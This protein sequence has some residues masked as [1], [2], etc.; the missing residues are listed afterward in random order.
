MLSYYVLQYGKP[1]YIGALRHIDVELC[2]VGALAM[3]FY[4]RLEVLK[5]R[6][7]N[8]RDRSSWYDI[9]VS[10][11]QR[12]KDQKMMPVCYETERHVFKTMLQACGCPTKKVTHAGRAN[13]AK[14][15]AEA[16]VRR[17]DILAHGRWHYTPADKCYMTEIPT[18]SLLSMAGVRHDALRTAHYL[19]PR[20]MEPVPQ[21]LLDQVY[22]WLDSEL[23]HWKGVNARGDSASMDK[24]AEGFLTF[25]AHLRVVLFQDL[26][27]LQEKH[28]DLL[29]FREALWDSDDWKSYQLRVKKRAEDNIAVEVARSIPGEVA[30][31]LESQTLQMRSDIVR[32]ELALQDLRTTLQ[33]NM[34]GAS[35]SRCHHT[36]CAMHSVATPVPQATPSSARS[37]PP[38]P[39][40]LAPPMSAPSTPPPNPRVPVKLAPNLKTVLQHWDEFTRGMDGMPPLARIIRME[41]RTWRK[42]NGIPR[43][44]YH[45]RK[46]VWEAVVELGKKLHVTNN[47]AANLLQELQSAKTWS[48]NDFREWLTSCKAKVTSLVGVGQVY[49]SDLHDAGVS[50]AHASSD[51]R[52]DMRD[53]SDVERCLEFLV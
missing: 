52:D 34:Q 7:P 40:P 49:L 29:I 14:L 32:L 33:A 35:N 27:L 26:A 41:S 25:L 2:P 12:G 37:A 24:A 13:S 43:Q 47:K 6:I 21:V 5:E 16:G 15:M 30:R 23:E 31:D 19:L 22:P 8:F 20:A 38:T 18:S 50:I 17:E 9:P 11:R 42:D 51:A 46:V 39:V 53:V 3:M 36:C 44:A 45:K 4:V 28:P 10:V 1:E 48:M